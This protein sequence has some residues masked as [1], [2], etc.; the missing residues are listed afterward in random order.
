MSLPRVRAVLHHE[1]A[2]ARRQ[3]DDVDAKDIAEYTWPLLVGAAAVGVIGVVPL[4]VIRNDDAENAEMV[5][6][7]GSMALVF[8]CAAVVAW[9]F[10]VVISGL[11]VM[12]V[13]RTAPSSTSHLVLQMLRDSFTRVNDSS[14]SIVLLALLAG[15]VSLAIGL[16]TRTTDEEAHSVLDDLLA[17]QVGVLIFVLGFAFITETVR[18]SADIVDDQSPLLAWPWSLLIASLSWVLATVAGPFEATRMLAVLLHE[19][20]PAENDGVPSSQLIAELVPPSAR[21]WLAFGALPVIA[22]LWA[23]QAWKQGGFVALRAFLSEVT[24]PEKA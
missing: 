6:L 19:W 24:E 2:S 21:W 17:A 16:P 20:L 18:C 8:I 11:V 9:L 12:V 14:G 5:P 10:A 15:L 23:Y 4:L 13:Y 3:T 1:L 22:V 7:L